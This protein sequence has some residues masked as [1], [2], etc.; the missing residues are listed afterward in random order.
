MVKKRDSTILV[1]IQKRQN[2]SQAEHDLLY[3]SIRKYVGDEVE[4]TIEYVDSFKPLANGKRS[5]LY[6]Q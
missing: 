1:Q 5:F 2:Y 3:E 4:I 6:N